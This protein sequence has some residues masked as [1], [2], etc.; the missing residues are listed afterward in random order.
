[1]PLEPM[2]LGVDSCPGRELKSYHAAHGPE[3]LGMRVRTPAC[4]SVMV[5]LGG[6]GMEPWTSSRGRLHPNPSSQACFPPEPQLPHLKKTLHHRCI[7][8]LKGNDSRRCLAYR[9]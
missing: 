4:S 2:A 1:M 6:V 3:P 5:L 8:K 9:G 7:M